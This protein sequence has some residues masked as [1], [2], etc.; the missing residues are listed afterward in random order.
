MSEDQADKNY[1][2]MLNNPY[3]NPSS[4]SG[5]AV[6]KKQDIRLKPCHFPAVQEVQNILTNATKDTFLISESDEPFEWI[7]IE[8]KQTDLP[9]TE[10]ELVTLGLIQKETGNF[11]IEPLSDCSLLKQQD[12]KHIISACEKAVTDNDWKVYR[13]KNEQGT[14]TTILV[15][16]IVQGSNNTHALVGLKS[17]LVQT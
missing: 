15:L 7:N 14:T 10:K 11:K 12:Y 6:A 2:S 16:S 9:T 17:L 5:E 3:I 8:I 1:M 13:V 4:S